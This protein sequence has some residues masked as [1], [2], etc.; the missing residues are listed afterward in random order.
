MLLK[1]CFCFLSLISHYFL[2]LFFFCFQK[3]LSSV[4]QAYS[5]TSH[6]LSRYITLLLSRNVSTLG[7]CRSSLPLL[8]MTISSQFSRNI[9]PLVS[10]KNLLF[11]IYLSLHHCLPGVRSLCFLPVFPIFLQPSNLLFYE[12]YT[13]AFYE[14]LT[15]TFYECPL[16]VSSNI[17]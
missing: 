9:S 13:S 12:Y 11:M 7:R 4:L 17:S 16:C 6:L 8:S 10:L 2:A 14:Y 1:Q 5:L 3:N 15:S